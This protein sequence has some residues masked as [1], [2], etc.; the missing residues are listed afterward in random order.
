MRN[1]ILIYPNLEWI[2]ESSIE[3]FP[4]RIL[5]AGFIQD[6]VLYYKLIQLFANSDM[7]IETFQDGKSFN[8]DF[9]VI[10]HIFT[11]FTLIQFLIQNKRLCD[12]IKTLYPGYSIPWTIVFLRLLPM[13]FLYSIWNFVLN[14]SI[15]AS[16]RG[17]IYSIYSWISGNEY[18][19]SEKSLKHY[20]SL[21]ISNSEDLD[22]LRDYIFFSSHIH[23]MNQKSNDTDPSILVSP[24]FGIVRS[25]GYIQ[26][27]QNEVDESNS[28][29]SCSPNF[30]P[31]STSASLYYWCEAVNNNSFHS[32]HVINTNQDGSSS[33]RVDAFVGERSVI[34]QFCDHSQKLRSKSYSKHKKEYIFRTKIQ[35]SLLKFHYASSLLT[36]PNLSDKYE[37]SHSAKYKKLMYVIIDAPSGYFVSPSDIEFTTLRHFHGTCLPW[38]TS[39]LFPSLHSSL[40]P[41]SDRSSIIG[42]WDNGKTF[43]M[44]ICSPKGRYGDEL[45][46]IY[47]DEYNPNANLSSKSIDD[48]DPFEPTRILYATKTQQSKFPGDNTSQSSESYPE[49]DSASKSKRIVVKWD[50]G[51]DLG[52]AFVAATFVL[53]FEEPS[54][55]N[56][57]KNNVSFAVNQGQYVAPKQPLITR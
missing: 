12:R 13:R 23:S 1:E 19:F 17:I 21:G 31:E 52:H 45:L 30:E 44:T 20:T 51:Q 14:F 43:S 5:V 33:I 41:F 38:I 32:P 18:V 57:S 22:T 46:S 2:L 36:I 40:L 55:C 54:I 10:G 48:S 35:N 11:F 47:P 56:G 25:V 53:I 6:I 49:A 15:P 37:K 7:D 42:N 8:I 28:Y 3:S 29:D 16:L 26:T 50:K 24:C 39:S 4:G 34:K 27:D 9:T